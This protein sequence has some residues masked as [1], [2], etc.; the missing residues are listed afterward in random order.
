MRAGAPAGSLARPA[1]AAAVRSHPLRP[2]GIARRTRSRIAVPGRALVSFPASSPSRAAACRVARG[3]RPALPRLRARFSPPPR[4][5][6][7]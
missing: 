1:L 6:G 4:R 3:F 7:V 2:P 5:D